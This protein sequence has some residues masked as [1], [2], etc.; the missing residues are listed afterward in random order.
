MIFFWIN[1]NKVSQG[2]LAIVQ[3]SFYIFHSSI[4]NAAKIQY[5]KC[6]CFYVDLL[7]ASIFLGVKTFATSTNKNKAVV[8]L[9]RKT[10]KH[11]N[12][13]ICSALFW[14]FCIILEK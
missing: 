8:K 10:S 14:I 12:Q 11:F 5:T 9:I 4:V 6:V 1:N 7:N 3:L 13:R 2:Q